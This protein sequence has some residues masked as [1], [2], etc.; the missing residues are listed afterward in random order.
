MNE[1]EE[2]PV[3]AVEDKFELN[4]DEKLALIKLCLDTY[5]EFIDD[6]YRVERIRE[7]MQQ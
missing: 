6:Y 5:G 7:I 2:Q 4:E 3:K 1:E